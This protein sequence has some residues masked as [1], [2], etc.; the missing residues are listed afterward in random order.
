MNAHDWRYWICVVRRALRSILDRGGQ[1]RLI[2]LTL[3]LA[4]LLPL[5]TPPLAREELRLY[6]RVEAAQSYLWEELGRRGLE[7]DEAADPYHSGFIGL[8]WS[9]T[10]TTLGS[11][12]A[13]RCSTDPL[14]A[15]QAL[16]WFDELKLTKGDRVTVLASS[17]FPGL[18]YA[19]LAA[20]EERGL[21]VALSVSLGSSAWGANR[22]EFPWPAMAAALRRGGFLNARPVLYTLG[23]DNENGG[24]MPAEA[25]DLLAAAAVREDRLEPLRN[26]TLEEVIDAKMA[27]VRGAR[28]VV[29]IGGSEGNLGRSP[30][31]LGLSSGL[32]APPKGE[33]GPQRSRHADNLGDGVI[34]RTLRSGRPVLHLL[35]LRGLAG[36]CG[37]AWGVRKL[38]FQGNAL[39]GAIGLI[40]FVLFMATHRRW[41]WEEEK[42]ERQ[43]QEQEIDVR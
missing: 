35:N 22:P 2:L 24:G 29:S 4:G 43:E 20:A 27:L 25:R 9:A 28:L 34:G 8:E 31:V 13:K 30:D 38:G 23:G 40:L 17:S 37:I 42:G 41:S 7:R 36:V 11:L 5:W 26:G 12:E 39:V 18:V 33:G 10:A 1:A 15:V 14:W 19:I 6:R 16:R 3:M 21:D 32:I